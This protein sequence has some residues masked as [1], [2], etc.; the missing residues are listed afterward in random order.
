MNNSKRTYFAS[1]IGIIAFIAVIAFSIAACGELSDNDENYGGN[2][3][4]PVKEVLSSTKTYDANGQLTSYSEYEYDYK[5][6]RTKESIYYGQTTGYAEYEYN[7]KGNRTKESIYING[8]LTSRYEYEYDSKGNLTK[9]SSYNANGQLSYYYEYE[10]DFK[11]NQTKYSSFNANGQLSYYYEYEY[12][13]KG[14]LTKRSSYNANG[15]LSSYY[16]NEFNSKGNLTKQSSY[17]ANGQLSSYYEYE[18]DSKGNQTKYSSYNANGQLSYY[19]EY[20]YDF[21]GNQTKYSSFNANGQLSSYTIYIYDNIENIN[22]NNTNTAQYTV[23][24][25]AMGAVGTPP[26]SL[27]VES[28]TKISIRDDSGF[29]RDGYILIGWYTIISGTRTDFSIGQQY[30]VTANVTFMANWALASTITFNLN[31]GTGEVP[32]SRTVAY[33][34][35]IILPSGSGLSRSGYT[36]NGWNTNASASG[37][38]YAGGTEYTVN[39]NVTLYA[40]WDANVVGTWIAQYS[41]IFFEGF[42]SVTLQ[43][44]TFILNADNTF[45]NTTYTSVGDLDQTQTHYGIYNIIGSTIRIIFDSMSSTT[46][47]YNGNNT[48]SS[49]YVD[50]INGGTLLFYKQ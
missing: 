48:M 20:E 2:N 22:G 14:N 46:L 6:N 27:T 5:G 44:I 28:G 40:R 41:G 26:E 39:S 43:R 35:K 25:N 24:Y 21:K 31:N 12:D 47:I 34:S 16:E 3:S 42:S 1:T 38:S 29:S 11:G 33:G 19:Y 15:Q 9:Y 10:Y 36:F 50:I 7:S 45:T 4:N 49:S 23:Y 18:H 30:T 32:S 17:N 13:S 37:T 8:Q